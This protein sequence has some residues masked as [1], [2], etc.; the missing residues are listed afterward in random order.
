MAALR[1]TKIIGEIPIINRLEGTEEEG[2]VVGKGIVE[3][4]PSGDQIVHMDLSGKT[5]DI[6]RRGFS[7]GDISLY[8]TEE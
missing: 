5:A 2:Q 3:E 1:K 7:L 6:L 4:L 8:Q